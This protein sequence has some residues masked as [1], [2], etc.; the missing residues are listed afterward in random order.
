MSLFCISWHALISNFRQWSC[1]QPSDVIVNDL[2][3]AFIWRQ[4]TGHTHGAHGR[5]HPTSFHG[6]LRYGLILIW[7]LIWFSKPRKRISVPILGT[8][9][10]AVLAR[11][12]LSQLY[13]RLSF[14]SLYA[15]WSDIKPIQ[16]DN[17]Y[18]VE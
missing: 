9:I 16:L 2:F 6:I 3:Q 11:L 1:D 10:G 15:Y 12:W 7:I 17:G 13:G 5:S 14:W 4:R 8:G 18:P